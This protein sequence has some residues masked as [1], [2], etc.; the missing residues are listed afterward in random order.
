M[1]SSP[2]STRAVIAADRVVDAGG[3]DVVDFAEPARETGVA[4]AGDFTGGVDARAAV[5]A[6]VVEADLVGSADAVF[7]MK[8]GCGPWRSR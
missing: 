2:V 4:G 7:V 6:G 3:C 5:R 8:A 1:M